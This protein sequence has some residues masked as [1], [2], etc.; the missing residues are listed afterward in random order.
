MTAYSTPKMK[1]MAQRGG[2]VGYIEKPFMIED[3][4][5]QATTTLRKNAEGGTLHNVSSGMFLQLIEMEERTC[6]IRLEDKSSGKQGILFFQE[7]ELIDAKTE[8]LVGELAAYEIFSWDKVN[9]SIQ[10]VCSQKKRT[11]HS[12]LQAIFL[13]AMQLKDETAQAE[14]PA[15]A[16]EMIEEVEEISEEK[17]P[18]ILDPIH[19][20]WNRLGKDVGESAGIENIY[21][22]SSWDDLIAQLAGIGKFF[23]AGR[24]M[25]GH[26]DKGEIH[27]FILL[28]GKEATVVTVSPKCPRDKLLQ[29][30]SSYTI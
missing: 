29:I 3:L 27:N 1:Q 2:A 28:P 19:R 24:F 16:T 11:I 12:D 20:I 22:D 7:G 4:A 15:S 26:I 23:N 6:T 5:R 30:L 14:A 10:N 25:V 21:H 8:G 9:L 17:N 18:E 13:H